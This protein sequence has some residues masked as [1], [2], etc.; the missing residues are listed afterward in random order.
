MSVFDETESAVSNL[1]E[2]QQELIN[3]VHLSLGSPNIM[4]ELRNE[5][6]LLA[7]NQ[8]QDWCTLMLG[9]VDQDGDMNIRKIWIEKMTVAL[10]QK[11]LG[12]I[13][14]KFSNIDI[15]KDNCINVGIG[16]VALIED[17]RSQIEYLLSLLER[18]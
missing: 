8:A 9:D 1:T 15:P 17:A 6:I 14:S 16:G 11:M 4:V 18:M 12:L 7:H 2:E 13:R 10:S 5:N 3:H